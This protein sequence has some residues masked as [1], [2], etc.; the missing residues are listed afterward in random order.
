MAY[1]S[2]GHAVANGVYV[3]AVNRIGLEKVDNDSPGIEFWG[4]SFVCDPQGMIIA[5]H[6]SI[7]KKFFSLKLILKELNTLDTIGLPS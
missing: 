3:A 2:R 6:L 1:C 7:K 4:Q 5:Q